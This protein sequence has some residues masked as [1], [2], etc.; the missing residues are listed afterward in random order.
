M[1]NIWVGREIHISFLYYLKFLQFCSIILIIVL[2]FWMKY[3]FV[4]S[5]KVLMNEGDCDLVAYYVSLLPEEDRINLYCTFMESITEND[6]RVECL[7][8]AEAHELNIKLI[9]EKVVENIRSVVQKLFFTV[10][11]NF[12]L[13]LKLFFSI[14]QCI[15]AE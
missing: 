12:L 5:L 3:I 2:I 7:K 10:K 8:A 9:V 11:M 6:K 4:C 15:Q 13:L 1:S 14:F